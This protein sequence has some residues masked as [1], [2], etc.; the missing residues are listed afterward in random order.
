VSFDDADA[1]YRSPPPG[2]RVTGRDAA[3]LDAARNQAL[4]GDWNE[5]GAPSAGARSVKGTL[6]RPLSE[7]AAGEVPAYE[8]AWAR[9]VGWTDE[10]SVQGPGAARELFAGLAAQHVARGRLVVTN[11]RVVWFHDGES[12]GGSVGY[13][14]ALIAGSSPADDDTASHGFVAALRLSDRCGHVLRL[15]FGV[16]GPRDALLELLREHSV[17]LPHGTGNDVYTNGSGAT[18]FAEAFCAGCTAPCCAA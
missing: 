14:H 2:V 6:G 12:G 5:R 1:F 13:P 3:L 11:R 18:A 17:A 8:R 7:A 10:Y 15:S 9:L 4:F 16:R